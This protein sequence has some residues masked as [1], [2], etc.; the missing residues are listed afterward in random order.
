LNSFNVD[1]FDANGIGMDDGG[2]AQSGLMRLRHR[3]ARS[4]LPAPGLIGNPAVELRCVRRIVLV[5]RWSVRLGKGRIHRLAIF[6]AACEDLRDG[7][8]HCREQHALECGLAARGKASNRLH[9]HAEPLRQDWAPGCIALGHCA[10]AVVVATCNPIVSLG[11]MN[12]FEVRP[13]ALPQ[14]CRLSGARDAGVRHR[15]CRSYGLLSSVRGEPVQGGAAGQ[16]V[17]EP[18]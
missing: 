4:D 5:D 10:D 13:E 2:C 11:S 3:R 18:H 14:S 16:L 12:D 1:S 7:P 15:E 6:S 9:H 8:G 17:L